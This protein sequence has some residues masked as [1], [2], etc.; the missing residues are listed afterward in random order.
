ME[1]CGNTLSPDMKNYYFGVSA[2]NIFN[3]KKIR[4]ADYVRSEIKIK[5]KVYLLVR[6]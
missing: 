5:V 3:H 2:Y 4:A 6:F 1:F